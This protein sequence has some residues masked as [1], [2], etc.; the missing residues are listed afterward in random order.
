MYKYISIIGSGLFFGSAI[1]YFYKKFNIIDI[2]FFSIIDTSNTL[3][4]DYII[5]SIT[6]N[7]DEQFINQNSDE[8]FINRLIQ[9]KNNV[10]DPSL[11]KITQVNNEIF[12]KDMEQTINTSPENY[13]WLFI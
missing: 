3:I 8:Q 4:H 5:N 2:N 9:T 13:K 10:D 1:F 7:S 6:Q 11:N 12:T